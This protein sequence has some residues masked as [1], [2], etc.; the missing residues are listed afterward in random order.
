MTVYLHV[1]YA[2]KSYATSADF[3][4][5]AT[6]RPHL[7]LQT[8]PPVIQS[9]PPATQQQLPS[10]IRVQ[11][12][13]LSS[14]SQPLLSP[15]TVSDP[16]L[17]VT[18]VPKSSTLALPSGTLPS[19]QTVSTAPVVPSLFSK[20]YQSPAVSQF[21]QQPHQLSESN[22]LSSIATNLPA[23]PDAAAAA[24]M[25]VGS[26]HHSL[27][28]SSAPLSSSFSFTT[29]S[30]ASLS[31]LSFPTLPS[32]S[33]SSLSTSSP[34]PR[35]SQFG[36]HPPLP[37]TITTA[38]TGATTNVGTS[39]AVSMGNI[40]FPRLTIE[41]S[42][43]TPASS[44]ST[45]SAVSTHQFM[46]QVST[47]SVSM[48]S[49]VQALGLGNI[50]SL[51]SSAN[52]TNNSQ[53]TTA[54]SPVLGGY[55]PLLQMIQ[56][57]KQFHSRGDTQGMMKIKQQLNILIARQKIIA[58]QNSLRAA[59]QQQ[60]QQSAGNLPP[61]SSLSTTGATVS[62]TARLDQSRASSSSVSLSHP[63]QTLQ[64]GQ[65]APPQTQTG[66]H[67]P[68]SN[69]STTQLPTRPCNPQPLPTTLPQQVNSTV[70]SSSQTASSFVPLSALQQTSVPMAA[71]S[72]IPTAVT[73][74]TTMSQ[75]PFSIPPPVQ[76]Q[77]PPPASAPK[78]VPSTAM[79]S[80]Q[81]PQLQQ[82]NRSQDLGE[83]VQSALY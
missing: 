11:P 8:P 78:V 62:N 3:Q 2:E 45:T 17:G 24:A 42:G 41:P 68:A 71:P 1:K 22:S 53:S 82:T 35:P 23:P 33:T 20:V 34:K 79:S 29:T 15:A 6:K 5:P 56:L 50:T 80:Q 28:T 47:T 7:E 46:P 26:S 66:G 25:V 48:Q 30:N 44:A 55:N 59:Q 67:L 38:I 21:Q 49:Q 65:T 51:S 36:Y 61:G 14:S 69:F 12:L 76:A 54:T 70:L 72:G 77:A 57:Y 16:N 60:Q 43:Q 40:S 81:Q 58:A 52:S 75:T 32:F 63:P 83:L 13:N 31:Q 10:N 27:I 4:P 64:S 37:T 74:S 19:N 18:T 9:H 73:S 39:A